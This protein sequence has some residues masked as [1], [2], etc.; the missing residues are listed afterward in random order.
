[1]FHGSTTLVKMECNSTC[2]TKLFK[3]KER[4]NTYAACAEFM[5][6]MKYLLINLQ[7]YQSGCTVNLHCILRNY[8]CNTEH[9]QQDVMR[10]G[11]ESGMTVMKICAA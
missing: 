3:L 4:K 9:C 8:H 7:V 5:L 6:M 1:M 10:S 11:N 2:D